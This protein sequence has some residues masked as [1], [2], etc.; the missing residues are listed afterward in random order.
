M[1]LLVTAMI[2]FD[3]EGRA[4]M[5]QRQRP[6]SLAGM[7]EF[8][9]GKMEPGESP[10]ECLEREILEE[11]GLAIRVGRVRDVSY[12]RYPDVGEVLIL[13]YECSLVSTCSDADGRGMEG[14]AW[15]WVHP[16]EMGCLVIAPADIPIVNRLGK[17]RKGAG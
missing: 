5:T 14:Q 6:P 16:S 12:H 11:L 10:E 17:S 3:A 15:R 2:L 8:P 9:G 1:P 7:W 4:L 13:C